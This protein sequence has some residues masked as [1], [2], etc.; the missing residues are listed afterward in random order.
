MRVGAVGD[1][2]SILDGQQLGREFFDLFWRNIYRTGNVGFTLA[3]RRKCFDN[4]DLLVV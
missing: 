3:F 4:H 2:F 1:D